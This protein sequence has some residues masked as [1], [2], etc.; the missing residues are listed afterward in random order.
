MK[1]YY[2]YN[3]IA[4]Y[5]MRKMKRKVMIHLW[6]RK[7]GETINITTIILNWPPLY[8]FSWSRGPFL[9]LLAISLNYIYIHSCVIY[10][11]LHDLGGGLDQLIQV[12]VVRKWMH[13]DQQEE[14]ILCKVWKLELLARKLE[15][16]FKKTIIGCWF[17]EFTH[18]QS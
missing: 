18:K 13:T 10:R 12:G 17:S 3:S 5:I 6:I 4:N 11:K 9:W 14:S 1:K 8:R 2:L 15:K 7:Q 16:Y